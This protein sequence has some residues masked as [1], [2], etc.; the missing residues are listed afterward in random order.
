MG[1]CVLSPDRTSS[2]RQ[3]N[4]PPEL[5]PP[6]GGFHFAVCCYAPKC[7]TFVLYSSFPLL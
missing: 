4:R 5:C 1:G 6:A 3:K 7:M 2:R